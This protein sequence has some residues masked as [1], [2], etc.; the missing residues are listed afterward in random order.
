MIIRHNLHWLLLPLFILSCAKQSAPTGGPKD[1]I[2]PTLVRATPPNE[3]LN[4]KGKSL[5]MEFSEL[6][7]LNNPQEQ[8]IITPSIG[9][10]FQL[11]T[12]KNSVLLQFDNELLDNTTYTFNFREAV[13]DI[14]EKNSVKNFQIA[15]STGPYIDSLSIAGTVSD[16]IKTKEIKDA[17][18][19]LHVENDTFNVMKHPAS[20]FTKTD[21]KGRFKIN[22]LKPGVY[23]LYAFEDKNRNLFIDSKT[24]SYSFI[25]K[26]IHLQKDTSKI[27]LGLIRLDARPLRIISS[28]PYNTYYNIRTSKNLRIFTLEALNKTDLYFSFG[29]DQSNIKVYNTIAKGDSIQFKL[30]AEDS[31]GNIIDTTLYAK[32]LQ[33][34]ATPE[35]F[36]ATAQSGSIIA[37]KGLLKIN[38]VLS[39]PLK[40]IDFDSLYFQPDSAT[41]IA[42]TKEDISYDEIHRLL[43]IEKTLDKSLFLTK[44]PEKIITEPDKK[45]AS[46]GKFNKEKKPLPERKLNQL[47][48]GKGAL[49]SVEQDSSN[50]LIQ[51]ITPLQTEDLSKIIYDIKTQQK[52]IIIQLLDKDFK[53]LQEEFEKHKGEFTNL[54]AGEYL[55]RVILDKNGNRKWDLG[56]YYKNEA[57]ET[58]IYYKEPVKGAIAIKLKANWDYE[59]TPL[60]ISE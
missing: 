31:I 30:N 40:E 14:T 29:E 44:E 58:M 20:I 12:K 15:I 60:L 2:P 39:K 18:V 35:R 34:E 4:F 24:E 6:V 26:A 45:S 19:A 56:N 52:K 5:E 11:K 22:H 1:T 55:I 10:D 25:S 28:R 38:V 36:S 41:H 21:E 57:P 51:S 7:I 17:T 46:P 32:F 47:Y 23:H 54:T 59:L 37:D 9:K 53:V 8:L 27:T 49:I 42:F 33:Q 3:A 43:T 48:A 50:T 16:L 13:Q